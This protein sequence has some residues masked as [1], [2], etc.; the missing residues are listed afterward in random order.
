MNERL[1]WEGTIHENHGF[2]FVFCIP[3][4]RGIGYVGVVVSAFTPFAAS[5][6]QM[7][8]RI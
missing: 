7:I 1:G 3:T 5:E 6:G 8:I 4:T 2:A